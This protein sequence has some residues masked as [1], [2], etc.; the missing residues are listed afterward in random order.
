VPAGITTGAPRVFGVAARAI[1][2]SDGGGSLLEHGIDVAL[3]MTPHSDEPFAMRVG[4]G[5]LGAGRRFV[6]RC[7]GL[8]RG[9]GALARTTAVSELGLQF[10]LVT[11]ELMQAHE[12]REGE[13]QDVGQIPGTA[14]DLPAHSP[15]DLA[16]QSTEPSLASR[17]R[18]G[19]A[20]LQHASASAIEIGGVTTIGAEVSAT[21]LTPVQ[22]GEPAKLV[23][24]RGEIALGAYFALRYFDA[25]GA[26]RVLVR[27]DDVRPR[28]GMLDE[29]VVTLIRSPAATEERQFYRAP[30]DRLFT[31]DVLGPAGARTIRGQIIDLSA[32]GIG[33]RVTSALAPGDRLRV[34]DQSLPSLDGAMLVIIRRDSRDTQRYGAQFAEPEGGAATLATILGLGQAEREHR[35]RIQLEDVRRARG[36][37]AAPLSDSDSRS[38]Q[39][40]RMGTREHDSDR[41]PND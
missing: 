41:A 3:L 32:G 18:E 9:R 28:P 37:N 23:A 7:P 1:P 25:S 16:G 22:M 10:D 20:E 17:E 14:S 38:L 4:R 21:L 2:L 13:G 33:F 19:I 8:E 6:L 30:F 24:P 29:L 27:A 31:A 11:A 26:K 15:P 5:T 34:A 12:P 36:A 40:R 39:N 35:R